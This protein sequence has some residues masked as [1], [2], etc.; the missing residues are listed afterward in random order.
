[1]DDKFYIKENDTSPKIRYALSPST[2]SLA[3][4]SV[5]FK[6]WNLARTVLFTKAATIVSSSPPIVEYAFVAGD[7]PAGGYYE[8][9]FTVTYTDGSKETFPNNEYIAIIVGE[10]VV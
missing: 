2:V 8:G 9:E 4:A 3:S 6:M 5:V 10:N 1:M 7:I